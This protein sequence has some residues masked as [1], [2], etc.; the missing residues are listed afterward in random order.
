MYFLTSFGLDLGV[1]WIF[2][3]FSST[4]IHFPRWITL[5]GAGGI[6][7]GGGRSRNPSFSD[8]SASPTPLSP[9]SSS[10]FS[11]STTAPSS[12][13]RTSAPCSMTEEDIPDVDGWG[14]A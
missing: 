8:L 6:E 9:S 1:D 10:A 11:T 4:S 7:M 12:P 14:S 13:S 3:S 2:L 5:P